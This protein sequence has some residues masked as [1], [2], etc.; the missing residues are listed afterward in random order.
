M[1]ASLM[2]MESAHGYYLPGR[3]DSAADIH[4][5][6]VPG[7]ALIVRPAGR[8]ADGALMLGSTRAE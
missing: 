6:G 2:P 1:K 5:V 3:A 8:T 7:E 4:G